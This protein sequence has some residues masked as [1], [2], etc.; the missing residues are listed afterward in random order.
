MLAG[1]DKR[2]EGRADLPTSALEHLLNL[3]LA[4]RDTVLVRKVVGCAQLV[5]DG[6]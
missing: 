2:V 4:G 1:F 5:T 6:S 3:D